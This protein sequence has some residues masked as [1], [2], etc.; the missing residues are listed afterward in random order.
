MF[1]LYR[2]VNSLEAEKTLLEGLDYLGNYKWFSPDLSF[3]LN[4]VTD[5]KFNCSE[6]NP[7]QYDHILK[8]KIPKLHLKFFKKVGKSELM[9]SKDNFPLVDFQEIDYIDIEDLNQFNRRN[10]VI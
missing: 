4:R 9:L 8:F 5:G 3:I 1:L 2:A 7:G 6:D 10:N